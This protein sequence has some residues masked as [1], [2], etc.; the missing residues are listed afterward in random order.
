MAIPKTRIRNIVERLLKEGHVSSPAVPVE[1]LIKS[2][3]IEV[4]KRR[5][6]DDTSGFSFF[7]RKTQKNIIGLNSSHAPT[8][9]RFTLAHEL[10][11]I[12][13]HKN[14]AGGLHVDEHDIR[15]R[16]RDQRSAAGSD[17]HEREANA[18]AAELLMPKAFLQREEILQD[19]LSIS[20]ET[21]VRTL[22]KQ[23]GV[24]VHALSFRLLN[25]GL[26]DS[27]DF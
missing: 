7:D 20:S 19:G 14:E 23:Y 2:Q 21:A 11:H 26:I 12:L 22:A 8:R 5:F 3:G 16:F 25:L 13:L 17:S 10:G 18:F 1:A 15:F 24:S 4:I 9:Q 27:A 6:D